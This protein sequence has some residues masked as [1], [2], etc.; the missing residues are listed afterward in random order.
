MHACIVLCVT[1]YTT[2][3]QMLNPESSYIILAYTLVISSSCHL[4]IFFT[5]LFH[6]AM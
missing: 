3:L 1:M 2:N 4:C 6:C 5:V